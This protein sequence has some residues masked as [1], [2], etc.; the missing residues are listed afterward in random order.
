M[1][2]NSHEIEPDIVR[3]AEAIVTSFLPFFPL[4]ERE[5][6]SREW[7]IVPDQ[8]HGKGIDQQ[9]GD[10]PA[11]RYNK[12]L[13]G[14]LSRLGRIV[15]T[16]LG[17]GPVPLPLVLTAAGRTDFAGVP[18]IE[19]AA[20]HAASSRGEGRLFD[21]ENFP[22]S[23][24]GLG[25]FVHQL[26]DGAAED[27]EPCRRIDPDLCEGR[28]D[29]L[30]DAFRSVFEVLGEERSGQLEMAGLVSDVL[31]NDGIALVEA[32]TGMG[33]SLAYLVPSLLHSLGSG[34]RVIVSTHTKNLQDQLL[35]RE[36]PLLESILART[37]RAARLMGRE[38]YLCA[39]KLVSLFSRLID[40]DPSGAL[41]LALGCALTDEG[42]VVSLAVLPVGIGRASL[43]APRRCRASSCHCVERCPL[44]RARRRAR[45]SQILFVNHALLMTD[46]RQGNAV[47]GPYE[48]VI[49]DEAHNLE[50]CI[51]ENLS[52]S[53][54]REDVERIV[55]PLHPVSPG[56]DR[57]KLLTAELETGAAAAD[58]EKLV[59]GIAQ[60]MQLIHESYRRLFSA[61]QSDLNEFAHSRSTRTRY[62]DGGE[63][64]AGTSS[65]FDDIYLHINQLLNLF[66]PLLE[67]E[68]PQSAQSFQHEI[69]SARDGLGELSEVLAFLRE[70]GDEDFVYWLE[71]GANGGL[72]KICGSPLKVDRLFADYIEDT[73]GSAVF[74]SATLAQGGSFE[75][76]ADRLGLKL[77]SRDRRELVVP[78]PFDY[79]G[80]CLILL[81]THLGNPNDEG[82][83]D[84]IAPIVSR[85]ATDVARRMMVLF[86]SY[87]L[88]Q[89]TSRFLSESE[90]PGPLLIQNYG[91][92][93]EALSEQF[94]S[95]S[96]GVLLGVASFWE[97]VDFPGEELEILVIPKIPFPVP[98]EPIIEAR[99]ERIS[100]LGGNAFETLFIPEAVMRLR[101]G[102]GRLIRRRQDR[103][104]VVI[105]DSRLDSKRYGET[106]LASLPSP[107][108]RVPSTE[109]IITRSLDWLNDS[110]CGER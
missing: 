9:S 75:Y 88:C 78:S 54:G 61:I 8:P 41:A 65:E 109:E 100:A 69:A 22:R 103:G 71:W 93:R 25:S 6:L 81:A 31:S 15:V 86:T 36:V 83:V 18:L 66:K 96:S 98:S 58:S 10:G 20:L 45:E 68:A 107:A 95:S 102:V 97:G 90:I 30:H 72:A 5:N 60:S 12:E 94:R 1:A 89:S 85:L 73:C 105:L 77:T 92:S 32:G 11:G 62:T 42:T 51:M 76:T 87:R 74:T 64:F 63:T 91:E 24:D 70:G 48:R 110:G 82:F 46:Y 108:V 29:S 23:L 99:S 19:L 38:S 101:Q 79:E 80:N 55:E 4:T 106:V 35:R 56:D 16:R 50:R 17:G 37:V 14:E 21:T 3:R 53:A 39:R 26:L 52:L 49:F 44:M 13:L 34:E 7:G 2:G 33:K 104:I 59:A 40:D 57:W 84:Q 27:D 67:G 47:I 43:A 28:G